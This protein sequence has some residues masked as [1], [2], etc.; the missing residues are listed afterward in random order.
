MFFGLDEV[1]VLNVNSLQICTNVYG[2]LAVTCDV[3][4]ELLKQSIHSFLHVLF[5]SGCEQ[6]VHSD[7]TKRISNVIIVLCFSDGVMR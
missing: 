3:L 2:P 6:E 1:E 5:S 7:T 4:G